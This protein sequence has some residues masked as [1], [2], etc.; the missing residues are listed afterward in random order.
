MGLSENKTV[1]VTLTLT[2][3]DGYLV[4]EP[5]T[6]T[7]TILGVNDAPSFSASRYNFY[8]DETQTGVPVGFAP[9]F[10]LDP[11]PGDTL[12]FGLSQASAGAHPYVK[13]DPGTGEW[14]LN[15]HYDIDDPETPNP[16]RLNIT[17]SDRLGLQDSAEVIISIRDV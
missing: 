12:T 9:D 8:I 13:V 10:V 3:F 4:S 1:K 17:V 15:A 5:G 7:I 6:L 16:L 2:A 11:D 14:L